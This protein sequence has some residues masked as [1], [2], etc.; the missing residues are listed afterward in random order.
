MQ[1]QLISENRAAVREVYYYLEKWDDARYTEMQHRL[2]LRALI[3]IEGALGQCDKDLYLEI[4]D[5]ILFEL[6]NIELSKEFRRT[7]RTIGKVGITK[8]GVEKSTL[9]AQQMWRW[10]QGLLA[11]GRGGG[12]EI[13][14]WGVEQRSTVTSFESMG[15]FV[16]YFN[17]DKGGHGIGK[18]RVDAHAETDVQVI[19]KVNEPTVRQVGS[20]RGGTSSAE[21]YAVGI[22]VGASAWTLRNV[23]AGMGKEKQNAENGVVWRDC[24]AGI[25][26]GLRGQAIDNVIVCYLVQEGLKLRYFPGVSFQRNCGLTP[27]MVISAS[28]S[29]ECKKLLTINAGYLQSKL[30]NYISKDAS[31]SIATRL[32]ALATMAQLR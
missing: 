8:A 2:G 21:M 18:T 9:E 23:L 14:K 28:K 22:L 1:I 32:A 17:D 27:G 29:G 11:G 3:R 20:G 30:E 5:S 19:V 24:A 13:S 31:K 16:D 4:A 26:D 15:R 7:E 6:G 25:V 12:P 10:A